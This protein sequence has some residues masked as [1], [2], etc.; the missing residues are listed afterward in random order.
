MRTR[1][2][3]AAALAAAALAAG[4][5]AAQN[6]GQDF[7]D[8]AGDVKTQSAGVYYVAPDILGGRVVFTDGN[9]FQ[10]V[11]DDLLGFYATVDSKPAAGVSSELFSVLDSGGTTVV[12]AD[13]LGFWINSDNNTATGARPGI[14]PLGAEVRLVVQGVESGKPTTAWVD[15]WSPSGWTTTAIPVSLVKINDEFGV[16]V[17]PSAIGLQRGS[18]FGYQ[19][20]TTN[21]TLS[22]ERPEPNDI[23]FAPN[24]APA[25]S[26]ALPALQAPP[27]PVIIQAPAAAT[28]QARSVGSDRA[29]LTGTLDPRGQALNWYFEWG[30]TTR[31]GNRTARVA[32]PAGQT[33]VRPVTAALRRL[34][35]GAGYHYRLVVEPA[36]AAAVAG[37]DISLRTANLDRLVIAADPDGACQGGVCRITGFSVVVRGRDGDT[38][39][40]LKLTPKGLTATVRCLSGCSV[41][42]RFR[43]T[44]RTT[45]R[46][47]IGR[48]VGGRSLPSGAT[49]EVRVTGG[50]KWVGA[51]Y[52]ATFARND[53][54]DRICE[55]RPG[56]RP[57]SC[58]PA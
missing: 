55:I 25:F 16:L 45:L 3:T 24:A 15:T 36:S 23:D 20:L 53:L 54:V 10:S 13:F 58:G 42:T 39:R 35:A 48:L 34:T 8:T 17:S 46:A 21:E 50:S 32:V 5:A 57:S 40:L 47:E 19:V 2:I 27:P 30:R 9:D 44:G 28:T 49:I 29:T 14:V 37:A 12:E 7:T 11:T 43:L 22:P 33:G 56:A 26:F 52:R 4:P 1:T 18:T 31:Y 51:A 41:N 38:N 6:S